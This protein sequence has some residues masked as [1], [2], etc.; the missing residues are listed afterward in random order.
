MD[1]EGMNKYSETYSTNFDQAID[2]YYTDDVDFEYPGGKYNGKEAV[3]TY[4]GKVHEKFNEI[5][6]P[7]H[8]MID[9]DKNISM[10]VKMLLTMWSALWTEI[11]VSGF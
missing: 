9:G 7:V 4:F 6:R 1:R 3:R 8:L 2:T 10:Q 11:V 5:L